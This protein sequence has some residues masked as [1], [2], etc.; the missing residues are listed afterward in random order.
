MELRHLRHF[1]A[2]VDA[3]NLSKAAERLFISQPALTRSIKNLEDIVG[4]TLLERRPR[5]MAPT[6]AGTALY[7]YAQLMLNEAVRARAEIKAVQAGAKG[8]MTIG[9]ASM[10]SNHIIDRVVA[11]I[12]GTGRN[13]ALTVRQ[14]FLEELVDALRDGRLDVIFSNLS[15]V[16]LP[17]DLKVEPILDIRAFLYGGA[18]HPLVGKRRVDKDVLYGQKWVVG[19]Q[20]HARDFLDQ[21]F[22]GDGLGI[23]ELVVKTNSLNLIRSLITHGGFISVLP[24][25]LVRRQAKNPEMKLINAPGFPIIRKAGIITRKSMPARPIVD[26]FIGELRALCAGDAFGAWEMSAN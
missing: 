1:A 9:M 18:A 4:A 14:G 6:P 8:E 24:E 13:V 2:V 20:P 21:Y 15:N 7:R 5:G 3:G 12:C 10:F 26:R 25:H 23:P 11:T 17:V 16:V 19:D 22:S